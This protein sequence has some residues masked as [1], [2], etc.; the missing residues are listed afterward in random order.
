[1]SKPA[2][3]VLLGAV[4]ATLAAVMP[5]VAQDKE[6]AT[7]PGE[8]WTVTLAP[9]LWPPRWMAT[10]RWAASSRTSTSRSRIF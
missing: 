10:P 9:Y 1:M 5:V 8:R 6:T 7:P 3:R 4:A 2:T